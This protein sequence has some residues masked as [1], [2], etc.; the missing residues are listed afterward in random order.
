MARRHET[1]E[2]VGSCVRCGTEIDYLAPANGVSGRLTP[3]DKRLCD[4]CQRH[5][6]ALYLS[7]DEVRA[8]DGDLCCICGLFVPV[9]APRY[10]PLEAHVDHREA[11]ASGGGHHDENLGLAHSRCNIAKRDRPAEWRMDPADIR[12]LLDAWLAEQ[13]KP[14]RSRK[15][16]PVVPRP[17]KPCSV[18]GCD[19]ISA[20]K[21]MCAMHRR[22]VLRHGTTDAKVS[23]IHCSVS[24]CTEPI[25]GRGLCRI[26]L[27]A[28]QLT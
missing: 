17:K 22:R 9:G 16:V 18:E 27:T 6:P 2:P 25:R 24:G 23:N 15:S 12:P 14:K 21:D 7:A 26:H 10:H 1:L 4:S 28:G 3:I 13:A 5:N 11:L 19:R 8:R 20:A